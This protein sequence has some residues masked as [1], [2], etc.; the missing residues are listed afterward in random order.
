MISIRA[1]LESAINQE[2]R[3]NSSPLLSEADKRIIS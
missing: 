2:R 1:N 3:L